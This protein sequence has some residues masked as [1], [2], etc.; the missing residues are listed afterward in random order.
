ML[1]TGCEFM[2]AVKQLAEW[3]SIPLPRRADQP[4]EVFFPI[5][6]VA[7]ERQERAVEERLGAQQGIIRASEFWL[8]HETDSPSAGSFGRIFKM[9]ADGFRLVTDHDDRFGDLLR[10]GF[11]GM[12]QDRPSG[13]RDHRL[14][15]PVGQGA[16]ARAETGREDDGFHSSSPSAAP[17][18]PARSASCSVRMISSSSPERM[19]GMPCQDF[20]MRW[21]VTRSCG[22][23]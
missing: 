17:K 21:S 23:L 11:E 4:R 8:L 6:V 1:V 18:V 12:L 13:D 19:P 15:D 5:Q 14:R 7:V 16:Q 3:Y 9:P 2:E 10:Q 22:K 20:L